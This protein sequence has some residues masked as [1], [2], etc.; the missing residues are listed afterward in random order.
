MLPAS[1]ACLFFLGTWVGITV[2]TTRGGALEFLPGKAEEAVAFPA[3]GVVR[4]T[5]FFTLSARTCRSPP[6]NRREGGFAARP[7]GWRV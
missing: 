5:G 7:S 3:G 4:N 1:F 2:G 6:G